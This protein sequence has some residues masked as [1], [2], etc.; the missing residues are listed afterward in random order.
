VNTLAAA[1]F[2]ICVC[3]LVYVYVGY[4]AIVRILAGAFGSPERRGEFLP[5]VTIIITAYNEELGLRAKLD[6]VMSLEYAKSKFEILVVSD[7]SS[8]ATDL[9]AQSYDRD[10]VK[11]LRVEGR[12][13]KTAC[14]N[15]AVEVAA[16]EIVVI[17]DATTR[18]QSRALTALVQGFGDQTVG[19]VG[20]SL[21][22]QTK[23]QSL[24]GQGG[25]A[26]WGYELGL[27]RAE[28][29]LCSLVGVSGC[30]YAVRRSAYQPIPRELISDL[31][32]AL[33]I[34]ELGLRTILEPD[35]IC[36]EETHDR[37][38]TELSMRVRVAIRSIN[39]LVHER[40]LLNPFRFGAFSWQ[41]WSHKVLR[42][43]SPFFWLGALGA[44]LLL[45]DGLIY[46]VLLGAQI[47]VLGLGSIGF[48][49]PGRG[50]RLCAFKA[51]YYFLL[52]NVAS[53]LAVARYIAGER[54]VTW[55]PV[56]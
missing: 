9:I 31:V 14:Q 20:G 12:L 25:T 18:I 38:G 26:Y 21:V 3:T 53:F 13:G 52:T 42:Y 6:N 29:A 48:I 11:L 41:L 34:R 22:Y 36:F 15:A 49:V 1:I 19:C 10:R 54:M 24:T 32:I 51:P 46:R 56:R 43:A 35:A 55:E 45:V 16:G 40:R 7:A 27:R 2:W 23:S 47:I 33:R 4:P 37:L 50:V 44:N 5:S 17:T 30:L 39:A 28:S 8:D